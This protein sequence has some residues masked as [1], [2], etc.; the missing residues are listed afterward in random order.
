M[1]CNVVH[2]INPHGEIHPHHGPLPCGEL[3]AAG[4]HTVAPG[5]TPVV[6]PLPWLWA[7][8]ECLLALRSDIIIIIIIII[9][10]CI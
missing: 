6:V 7:G 3:G 5:P 10:H 2:F 9:M 4:C 1:S 8:Q